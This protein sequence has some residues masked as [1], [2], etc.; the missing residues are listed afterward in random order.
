MCQCPQTGSAAINEPLRGE[1]DPGVRG[2]A[3]PLSGNHFI[4]LNEFC[5]TSPQWVLAGPW[6]VPKDCALSTMVGVFGLSLQENAE[7]R[8]MQGSGDEG[9]LRILGNGRAVPKLPG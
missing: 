3:K 9:S 6:E 5:L 1:L 8:G 2:S 4:Q 7:S